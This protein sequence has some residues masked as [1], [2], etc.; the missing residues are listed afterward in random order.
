MVERLVEDVAGK[1]TRKSSS[2]L[3]LSTKKNNKNLKSKSKALISAVRHLRP[4][5][6]NFFERD[7]GSGED[8][9]DSYT[10]LSGSSVGN[11]KKPVMDDVFAGGRAVLSSNFNKQAVP[12]LDLRASHLSKISNEEEIGERLGLVQ[13]GKIVRKVL[14]N[15]SGEFFSNKLRSYP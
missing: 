4:G 2:S 3:S 14:Q 8:E 11:N 7:K 1:S 15:Q 13:R 5:L 9:G 12:M 6:P 10:Q